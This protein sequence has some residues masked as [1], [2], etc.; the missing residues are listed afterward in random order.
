MKT[1]LPARIFIVEDEIITAKAIE[2][3]LKD[4]GYIVVG[5]TASGEEAVIK[6]CELV[7]DLI[8][9]DVK[10]KGQMD[11]VSVTQRLRTLLDVPVIYL[12][13]HSDEQTVRRALHSRPYGFL[14]KPFQENE[15][16]DAI[17]AALVQHRRKTQG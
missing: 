17:Q 15:L 12:T 14:V 3:S 11:G 5:S 6:A 2:E 4:L 7:P 8:L 13:A 1:K 10:L 16:D 9:V